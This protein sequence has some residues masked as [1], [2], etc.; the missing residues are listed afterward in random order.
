MKNVTDGN[1]VGELCPDQVIEQ[2]E[3]RIL[4]HEYWACAVVED[5]IQNLPSVYGDY[6]YHLWAINGYK[7]GI[8]HIQDRPE[9]IVYMCTLSEAISTIGKA[10]IRLVRR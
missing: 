8:R 5:P 9:K 3:Y 1:Y 7:E 2:F 6:W 10:I 4:I